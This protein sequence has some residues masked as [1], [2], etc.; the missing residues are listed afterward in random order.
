V[1]IILILAR[2]KVVRGSST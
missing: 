2:K 1:V